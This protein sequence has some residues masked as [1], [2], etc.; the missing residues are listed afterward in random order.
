MNQQDERG[1]TALLSAL[2]KGHTENI[3][4][5][6][7]KGIAWIYTALLSFTV[8]ADGETEIVRLLLKNDTIDVN[9]RNVRGSTRNK[10]TE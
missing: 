8:T 7:Q 3:I 4:N 9:L 1:Q 6:N 5:V 2:Q 10:S